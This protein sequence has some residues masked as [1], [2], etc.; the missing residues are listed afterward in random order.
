MFCDPNPGIARWDLRYH[1][2]LCSC[3]GFRHIL[4]PLEVTRDN[5][6]QSKKQYTQNSLSK[7]FLDLDIS[8]RLSRWK[9]IESLKFEPRKLPEFQRSQRLQDC[10]QHKTICFLPALRN[11]ICIDDD[12]D[13][14]EESR[15]H[16]KW[17]VWKQTTL[18]LWCVSCVRVE[19]ARTWATLAMSISFDFFFRSITLS[20]CLCHAHKSRYKASV[21]YLYLEMLDSCV[22]P[23]AERWQS[24]TFAARQLHYYHKWLHMI[25]AASCRKVRCLFRQSNRWYHLSSAA[26]S[27]FALGFVLGI[28]IACK[29]LTCK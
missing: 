1:R 14:A 11:N 16:E 10:E 21:A 15:S 12:V 17:W 18:I 7:L 8:K 2:V 4:K 26:R 25:V 28:V 5:V 9:F 22:C 27:G 24:I 13:D 20:G 3:C 29:D 19:R 6:P 23:F